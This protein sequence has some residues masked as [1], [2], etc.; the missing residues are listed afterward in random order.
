[1]GMHMHV[2]MC[3]CICVCMRMYVNVRSARSSSIDPDEGTFSL[4]HRILLVQTRQ[5]Q[6][7]HHMPIKQLEECTCARSVSKWSPSVSLGHSVLEGEKNMIFILLFMHA[8]PTNHPP[9][10]VSWLPGCQLSKD[11]KKFC[12]C[13]GHVAGKFPKHTFGA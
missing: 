9:K 6:R 10:R 12:M 7:L 4:L 5:S 11:T 1:M 2:R 3:V 8:I 13:L